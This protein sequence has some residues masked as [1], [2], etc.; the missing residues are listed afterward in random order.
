LERQR[1]DGG[2]IPFR[3]I[4]RRILYGRDDVLRHLDTCAYT[5][6]A[7]TKHGGGRR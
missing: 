6:T 2:A 3:K 4:G 1:H 5:S 7:A